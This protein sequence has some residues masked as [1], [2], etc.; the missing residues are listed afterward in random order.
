VGD[1]VQRWCECPRPQLVDGDA[2][3]CHRCSKPIRGRDRISI[4]EEI[5]SALRPD[6]VAEIVAALREDVMALMAAAQEPWMD[7]EQAA[8]YA[9]CEVRRL[10]DLAAAD[11]IPHGHL[12]RKL[13]FKRSELDAYFRRSN[14]A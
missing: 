5:A 10:Q 11:Q 13:A 8:G 7:V 12:G 3:R 9:G 14:A 2:G 1:Q 6:L 4:V